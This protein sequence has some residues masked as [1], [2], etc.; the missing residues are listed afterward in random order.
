M[1]MTSCRP[2]ALYRGQR[3]VAGAAGRLLG[4]EL[5]WGGGL[6]VQNMSVPH[7]NDERKLKACSGLV[8][9][10]LPCCD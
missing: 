7:Q 1:I 10:L 8:Q 2:R 6:S 9:I 4:S 3:I 5:P